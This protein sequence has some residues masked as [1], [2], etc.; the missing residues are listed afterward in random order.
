[1]RKQEE[2]FSGSTWYQLPVWDQHRPS[3]APR[4]TSV[5]QAIFVRKAD[6][7]ALSEVGWRV[8]HNFGVGVLE[9]QLATDVQATLAR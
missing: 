5:V 4:D 6:H 8:L 7:E 9:E 2:K 3:L 1:M